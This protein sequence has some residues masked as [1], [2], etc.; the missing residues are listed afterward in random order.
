MYIPKHFESTELFPIEV[1]HKYGESVWQ[2]MDNRLLETIDY[3]REQLGRPVFV[4]TRNGVMKFQYRGYRPN[5]YK[6]TLYCS[7]HLHGRAV[8]FD[9]EGMSA[10]EVRVWLKANAESLPYP[11]WVE[12]GVDWVHIDVRQSKKGKVYLF[13]A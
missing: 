12:D 13:K 4:N 1:V 2:F 7:Q 10:A 3:I 8:D 6:S 9:V 11:I 5:T